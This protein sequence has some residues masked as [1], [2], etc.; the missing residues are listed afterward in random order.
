MYRG[1][2]DYEHMFDWEFFKWWI[3]RLAIVVAII[4]FYACLI[5]FPVFR[6]FILLLLTALVL[7]LLAFCFWRQDYVK[8]MEMEILK[9][10]H[11]LLFYTACSK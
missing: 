10:F 3:G 8:N 1:E 11:L 6:D 2:F 4:V 7:M 9:G 5:A